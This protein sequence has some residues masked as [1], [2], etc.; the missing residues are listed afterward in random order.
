VNGPVTPTPYSAS[1]P[2]PTSTTRE[3]NAR[4][5]ENMPLVGHLL[6]DVARRVPHVDRD[7]LSQAGMLALVKAAESYDETTGVP[8]GVYA[9]R[10]I[11]GAFADEL[12]SLDWAGRETRARMRRTASAQETLRG[13]LGREPR[14]AEIAALL[15]VDVAEV[16]AARADAGRRIVDIDDEVAGIAADPDALPEEMAHAQERSAYLALC[17]RAL[18]D[19]LRVVVEALFVQDRNVTELARELGVTHSAVSQRRTEALRLL[20]DGMRRRFPAEA[21]ALSAEPAAG[22][23]RRTAYLAAIADLEGRRGGLAARA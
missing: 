16:H 6:N 2:A 12:R 22:G 13:Q 7:D 21:P 14:P 18:P 3:R 8:F 20:G 10:R 17:I 1:V 15:G 4:V 11:L 9:R 23:A 19:G 5:V